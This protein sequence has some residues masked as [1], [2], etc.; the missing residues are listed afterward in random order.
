MHQK[1]SF[2]ITI[3]QTEESVLLQYVKKRHTTTSPLKTPLFLHINESDYKILLPYI[4]CPAHLKLCVH[5]HDE[6]VT[7]VVNPRTSVLTTTTDINK[8]L[9]E[10]PHN[11]NWR[12]LISKKRKVGRGVIERTL[13]DPSTKT[14]DVEVYGNL[15]LR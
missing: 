1:P 10:L 12:I 4:G 5:I 7:A 3:P 8:K 9:T 15:I 13:E 2:W 11:S 6:A 14:V